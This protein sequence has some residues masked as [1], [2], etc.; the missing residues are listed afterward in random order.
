MKQ[1]DWLK[2]CNLNLK[3]SLK[4][5]CPEKIRQTE[6]KSWDEVLLEDKKKLGMDTADPWN[7]SEWGDCQRRRLFK[8]VQPSDEDKGDGRKNFT[9]KP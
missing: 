1:F 3:A 4:H 2:Y 7:R 5:S 8:Q 9:F 6:R